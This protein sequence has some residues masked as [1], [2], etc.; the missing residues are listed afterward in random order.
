MLSLFPPCILPVTR[1]RSSVVAGESLGIWTCFET[2]ADDCLELE[3]S[4]GDTLVSG[5]L[6]LSIDGGGCEFEVVACV[7]LGCGDEP[8]DD[9]GEIPFFC[10]MS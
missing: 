4:P 2:E 5:G 7:M 3:D 6:C 8:M 9:W 10:D 1:A